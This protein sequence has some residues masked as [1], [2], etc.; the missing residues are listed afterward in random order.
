MRAELFGKGIFS[1]SLLRLSGEMANFGQTPSKQISAHTAHTMPTKTLKEI[2]AKNSWKHIFS[3]EVFSLQQSRIIMKSNRYL[4]LILYKISLHPTW[5]SWWQQ[6]DIPHWHM[7]MYSIQFDALYFQ[8]H[9]NL[10][11]FQF[12]FLN[13]FKWNDLPSQ[14]QHWHVAPNSIQ[15][16]AFY[17]QFHSNLFHFQFHFLN[18]FKRNDLQSEI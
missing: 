18:N 13:N 15:F 5:R 8:F 9:F 17:F 1:S 3:S 11:H 4:A 2:F 10:F 14:I 16:I 12:H 7:A 6:Y